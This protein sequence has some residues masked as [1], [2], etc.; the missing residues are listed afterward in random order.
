MKSFILHLFIIVLTLLSTKIHGQIT[1]DGTVTDSELNPISDALV[2]IIDETDTSNVY[3]DVTD[4]SGNFSISNITHIDGIRKLVPTDHIVLRN[5]PNPFNPTTMIYFELPKADNIEIK[6]YDILGRKVR[7]LYN[8]YKKAGVYHMSWDGR[9]NFG[10]GVAAGIYFC[11]LKTKDQFKVHKMVLL[12]GG[13]NASSPGNT[14]LTKSSSVEK[15]EQ[16]NS[17]FNFTVKVSGSSILASDFKYLGCSG[18]TTLNLIVPK[19]LQTVSIGYE[20]GKLET[21][22]FSLTIPEGAF[23]ENRVLELG[24][25]ADSASFDDETFSKLFRIDGL[26]EL[27]FKDLQ[28][29]I[30]LLSQPTDSISLAMGGIDSSFWGGIEFT[31]YD[32]YKADDSSGYAVASIPSPFTE[33]IEL[34]KAR[35]NFT[36]SDNIKSTKWFIALITPKK[37]RSRN[38]NFLIYSPK[39]KIEFIPEILDHLEDAVDIIISLGF[40]KLPLRS[41][42]FKSNWPVEIKIESFSSPHQ[43]LFSKAFASMCIPGLYKK[44][45]EKDYLAA[46][47]EIRINPNFISSSSIVNL[48]RTLGRDVFYNFLYQNSIN[49]ER[50]IDWLIHSLAFWSE[51]LFPKDNDHV[52]TLYDLEDMIIKQF[53]KQNVIEEIFNGLELPIR[54]SHHGTAVSA[55]IEFLS[56]KNGDKIIGDIYNSTI[57]QK[58]PI[59][60]LIHALN[61]TENIWWPNFF[62]DF[63]QGSIY[64]VPSEEFLK[65][66]TETIEFNDGD[67]LK[68]VDKTYNDLSAKLFKI[69]IN[70]EDIK[71]NK[72]LNFKIGP[73]SLN[74]DYVKTLV[75]GLANE[76]L[77]FISEGIDFSVGNLYKYDNLL[78]C[79]VNSGNVAPYTGS[80]NI[81][82]DVKVKDELQY[83]ACKIETRVKGIWEEH[84][85]P[86]PPNTDPYIYTMGYM[87]SWY[88]VGNFTDN[89]FEGV[90]DTNESGS[91]A[92]GTIHLEVDD[93]L[94]ISSFSV[95]A[96]S[97]YELENS[98]WECSGL[99]IPLK[100]KTDWNMYLEVVG[101]S[102]TNSLSKL[103]SYH[104]YPP[105]NTGVIRYTKLTDYTCDE[106]SYVKIT[107]FRK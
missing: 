103:Y 73:E 69:N 56:K 80:S 75:F 55:L 5:Y 37:V 72:S 53:L 26:P 9:N 21:D 71:N 91:G 99:N 30:K 86:P 104:E 59:G 10:G 66:V 79:V 107:L 33:N 105:S 12:D 54:S 8:N 84:R 19:I 15:N 101:A 65:N 70:S 62:K 3:S 67:T 22:D 18:D 7:T 97:H 20:G 39:S 47:W 63:I 82:I 60:G 34:L 87:S 90:I 89:V 68:Y 23:T 102:T 77:T 76:N 2:E 85:I 50:S 31:N 17:E 49:G 38:G 46:L 52:P 24:I 1:I 64:R 29:K 4:A 81:N 100:N 88:T 27:F 14:N 43:I 32:Y 94:N 58:S 51:K 48:K 40:N 25:E 36:S 96:F 44:I 45:N 95:K 74:L 11:R 35:N 13:T 6:I 92:T 16:I 106:N 28:L 57:S 98:Q 42:I 41:S 83:N 78:V 61:E 93:Q